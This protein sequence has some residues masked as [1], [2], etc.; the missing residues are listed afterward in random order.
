MKIFA[1]GITLIICGLAYILKPNLFQ[2]WWWKKTDI[3]QLTLGPE[4]YTVFTRKLGYFF[5]V[6]GAII[7]ISFSIITFSFTKTIEDNLNETIIKV[8]K[9]WSVNYDTVDKETVLS[10][11]NSTDGLGITIRKYPDINQTFEDMYKGNCDLMKNGST[12][13]NASE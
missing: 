5:V 3:L 10:T 8:P 6:F 13:L 4:K 12:Y 7:L 11:Y 1:L 9:S 2:R